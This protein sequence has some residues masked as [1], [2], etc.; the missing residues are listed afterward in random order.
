MKKVLY[1]LFL[2]AVITGCVNNQSSNATNNQLPPNATVVDK[3]TNDSY[4]ST[5]SNYISNDENVTK[6]VVKEQVLREVGMEGAANIERR[7]REEYNNG[8]GYTSKDGGRQIH[9]QGSKEQKRDLEMI[10]AYFNEHGWD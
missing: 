3:A 10:D 5:N 7:A 8:G 2:V 9:Y 4:S 1:L 6:S